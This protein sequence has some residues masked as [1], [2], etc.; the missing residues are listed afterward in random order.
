MRKIKFRAKTDVY[1]KEPRYVYGLLECDHDSRVGH[2]SEESWRIREADG[3][4]YAIDPETISQLLWIDDFGNEIYEGDKFV[5]VD[6]DG[7]ELTLPF[8]A[9]MT[10]TV[11]ELYNKPEGWMPLEYKIKRWEVEKFEKILE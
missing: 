6:E 3:R 1:G 2:E 4:C 11:A 5:I 7:T 8:V 10:S 9:K